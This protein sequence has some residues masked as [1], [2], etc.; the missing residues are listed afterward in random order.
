LNVAKNLKRDNFKHRGLLHDA[1][2]ERC[3]PEAT[4]S[5]L[6]EIMFSEDSVATLQ[7]KALRRRVIGGEN[8]A[9]IA[10]ALGIGEHAARKRVER[11]RRLLA[12]REL[13]NE[14]IYANQ[15]R[16]TVVALQAVTKPTVDSDGPSNGPMGMPPRR[17]A[18]GFLALSPRDDTPVVRTPAANS[19]PKAHE[20]LRGF[21]RKE[22]EHR[23]WRDVKPYRPRYPVRYRVI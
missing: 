22:N 3:D 10:A 1:D 12:N 9:E 4:A 19:G 23:D 16:S 18:G 13:H 20:R 14:L 6:L 11:E 5:D 21:R 17:S 15:R 8:Y 2:A 7:G